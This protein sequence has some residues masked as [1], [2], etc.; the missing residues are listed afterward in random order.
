MAI[1][2]VFGRLVPESAGLS[3][4]LV[5]LVKRDKTL[6]N[7]LTFSRQRDGLSSQIKAAG[8]QF[9]PAVQLTDPSGLRFSLTNAKI[10]SSIRPGRPAPNFGSQR[11]EHDTDQLEN[12][13]FV[14]ES[15]AVENLAGSTSTSDDWNA[16]NN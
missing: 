5:G 4:R 3:W 12:Y 1:P 9:L 16:N 15:I 13:S 7:R 8:T 11:S 6:P 14:F 2:I 10:L